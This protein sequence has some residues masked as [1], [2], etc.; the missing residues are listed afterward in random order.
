MRVAIATR[1]EGV[2]LE[3]EAARGMGE[4][5]EPAG[6]QEVEPRVA[7]PRSSSPAMDAGRLLERCT[8]QDEASAAAEMG[9]WR[10]AHDP[11]AFAEVARFAQ[12]TSDPGLRMLAL[13]AVDPEDPAAVEVVRGLREGPRTRP[14]A[15]L[16][17]VERRLEEPPAL[18]AAT[19]AVL[20]QPLAVLLAHGGPVE[21]QVAVL[22]QL[23]RVQDP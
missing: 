12:S 21:E 23:W 3:D 5:S 1:V 17:L 2:N 10:A 22:E 15:T 4:G 16:W 14:D 13:A 7:S 19:A 11:T 20:V 18:D 8:K 6:D 9:A